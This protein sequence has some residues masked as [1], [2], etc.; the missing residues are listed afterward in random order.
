MIKTYQWK[1][2]G[3]TNDSSVERYCHNCGRKVVFKDS[4]KRRRN[5]NG[6]TIYEYAIYKCDKD[7]TWNSLINTYKTL[8]ETESL[9]LNDNV[10]ETYSYDTLNLMVLREEGINEI[11]IVLEEVIGKWRIDKLL[12]DRIRDLSRTKI[13]EIIHNHKVLLD[14]KVVKKD[15]LLKKQQVIAILLDDLSVSDT[16]V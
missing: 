16:M 11:V 6:K 9:Q 12:G 1:L 2:I 10:T 14:G 7:H 13:S 3:V 5:A 8:N 15:S 4:R